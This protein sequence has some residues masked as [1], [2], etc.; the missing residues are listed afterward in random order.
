MCPP[1]TI[2]TPVH[3]AG[4]G[5]QRRGRLRLRNASI[6]RF[7]SSVLRAS[8]HARMPCQIPSVTDIFSQSRISAFCSRIARGPPRRIDATIFSTAASSSAADTG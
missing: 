8:T 4:A 6:I 1:R 2:G 3:V 7:G 5:H